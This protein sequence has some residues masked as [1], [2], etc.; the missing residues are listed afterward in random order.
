VIADEVEQDEAVVAV[1]VAFMC[2]AERMA[3]VTAGYLKQLEHSLQRNQSS[4]PAAFLLELG[5]ALRIHQWEA[6][7][8]KDAIDV[9]LPCFQA[10]FAELVS[11]L[12]TEPE[13]FIRGD[14]PLLLR[15]L[16]AWWTR[17]AHPNTQLLDVDVVLSHAERGRLVSCVAQLL[18]KLRDLETNTTMGNDSNEQ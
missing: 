6:A 17:C 13:R 7:G 15:V 14:A 5:A 2:D 18:W 11:R 1:I 12:Q 4:W 3:V 9:T 10:A 8:I 16:R